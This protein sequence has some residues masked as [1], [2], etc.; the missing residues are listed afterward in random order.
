M[1]ASL[2]FQQEQHQLAFIQCFRQDWKALQGKVH[3][4]GTR[5]SVRQ[6]SAQEEVSS[7][8]PSC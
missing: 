8:H 3:F 1:G 6:G 7:V 4:R 2:I 5:T